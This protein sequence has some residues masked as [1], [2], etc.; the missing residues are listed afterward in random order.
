MT[1]ICCSRS[2]FLLILY[3]FNFIY[4]TKLQNL[5]FSAL[6]E[7]MGLSARSGIIIHVYYK[8]IKSK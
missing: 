7:E 3:Y 8:G 4:V 5:M 2:L 1:D 6:R